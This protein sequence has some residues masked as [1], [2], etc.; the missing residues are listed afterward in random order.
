LALR[1]DHFRGFCKGGSVASRRGNENNKDSAR[2][3]CRGEAPE[4]L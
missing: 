4:R 2:I 3:L 1:I